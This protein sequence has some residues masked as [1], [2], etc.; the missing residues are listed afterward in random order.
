M[1]IFI[2]VAAVVAVK[3]IRKKR[4]KSRGEDDIN[5]NDNNDILELGE[6]FEYRGLLESR[7]EDESERSID[8]S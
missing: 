1:P 2:A 6:E 8:E 3:K 4:K 5:G 7:S